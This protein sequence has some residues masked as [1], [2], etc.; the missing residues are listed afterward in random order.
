M[1]NTTSDELVD[2]VWEELEVWEATTGRQIATYSDPTNRAHYDLAF[3]DDGFQMIAWSPDS[4]YVALGM[5][6]GAIQVWK[7]R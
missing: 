4:H 5:T 2:E 7:V 1:R 6:H 3:F